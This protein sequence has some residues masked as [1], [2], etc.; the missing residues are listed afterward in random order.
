MKPGENRFASGEKP[1]SPREREICELLS[2]GATDKEIATKLGITEHGVDFHLR[3]IFR[4]LG[5]H[6]RVRVAVRYLREGVA[7]MPEKQ[8]IS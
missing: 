4:K 2:I 5:T 7:Y 1:L 6:S 3:N 8:L